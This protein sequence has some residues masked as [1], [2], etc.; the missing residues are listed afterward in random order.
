[1]LHSSFWHHGAVDLD[2]RA[3]WA[4]VL[5]P[6]PDPDIP[7]HD[8][9]KANS[10][11]AA[12]DGLFLDFLYPAKTL[13][14][15]R[16]L[17]GLGRENWQSRQMR[18]AK[19]GRARHFSSH[20][21]GSGDDQDDADSHPLSSQEH[22]TNPFD[23]SPVPLGDADHANISDD[24]QIP[25]EEREIDAWMAEVKDPAEA[26]RSLLK[27]SESDSR[28]VRRLWQITEESH[29]TPDLSAD[30]L[31]Y[32]RTVKPF[33]PTLA[34]QCIAIFDSLDAANRRP[35]SYRGVIKSHLTLGNLGKAAL[36]HQGCIESGK[37][38]SG[39]IG[40]ADLLA[41]AIKAKKWQVAVEVYASILPITGPSQELWSTA[42]KDLEMHELLEPVL[43]DLRRMRLLTGREP[44]EQEQIRAFV[45]DFANSTIRQF[46]PF[47][48]QPAEALRLYRLIMRLRQNAFLEPRHVEH[49]L[50]GLLRSPQVKETGR[51][52]RI[53]RKLYTMYTTSI[54]T[55]D[56]SIKV[57]GKV[58]HAMLLAVTRSPQISKGTR[59]GTPKVKIGRVVADMIRFFGKLKPDVLALL[60]G[61]YARVGD[62]KA[63]A[64]YF[65][66]IPAQEV[67]PSHLELL[68]EVHSTRG[69]VDGAA[70][71]IEAFLEKTGQKPTMKAWNLVLRAYA[72]KGD[73]AGASRIFDKMVESSVKPDA[74][75]FSA[76]LDLMSQR[77]DI[78]GVKDMFALAADT[79]GMILRST[80]VAGYLVTA[81][82]NSDD[83][84]TAEM[85]AEQLKKRK[86]SGLMEGPLTPIWNNLATAYALRRDVD[87]TRRI[88]EEMQAMGLEPD[89][90]TYAA[91]LQALCLVRN[92]DAA[93][94][95][96]RLVIPQK[97]VK[98][99]ALHWAIVMAG[100]VNQGDYEKVWHVEQHRRSQGVRGSLSTRSAVIKAVA[101]SEQAGRYRAPQDQ[102]LERTEKVLM[103]TLSQDDAWEFSA[104]PQTGLGLRTLDQADGAYLDI[105]MLIYGKR[106]AFEMVERLFQEYIKRHQNV[107]LSDPENAPPIRTLVALMTAHFH[108]GEH[109]RVED[110]WNLAV[111]Q[112]VRLAALSA[113]TAAV[114]P[115][116]TAQPRHQL[117]P[118]RRHLLGRPL[119]IYL[120][121][122][123]VQG[124][125]ANA[126][127]TVTSLLEQ[128]FTL[129]NQSWNLYVQILARTG[130]IIEAYS[131]CEKYLMPQWR[132]WRKADQYLK[133]RYR[134]TRGWDFM[135]V[136]PNLV[137][138]NMVMPQYRTMVI[139]GAALQYV[140]RQQAV[141]GAARSAGAIGEEPVSEALI[142]LKAPGTVAAVHAMPQIDDDLQARFLRN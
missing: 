65:K 136:N 35:T 132:G 71:H 82:I 7:E 131:L 38:S 52:P 47:S 59:V 107:S 118:N 90:L 108:A 124:R 101:M 31:D 98:P 37:A 69:D 123:H 33:I 119:V 121:T 125:Y 45:T 129:D 141:G 9:P 54:I 19:S 97:P 55:A 76:V 29:R 23:V 81:F 57:S 24:L 68:V 114:H 72:R 137:K 77:G 103:N 4:S 142:R 92:T 85:V 15:M 70:A 79:D 91:L 12:Q 49:A 105:V 60:M 26:L 84:E 11:S 32:F 25:D 88:Y 99:M 40:T 138:P 22:D 61:T 122:L 1:M 13:A 116:S 30:V 100:F 44:E 89:A 110:C 80:E 133:R 139:L 102:A 66:K 50:L 128:G 56:R 48:T 51:L 20:A 27:A 117:T 58:M 87:G 42:R 140:R 17:S 135:N 41:H 2:L 112:G 74:Y 63:V 86:E 95:I 83:V 21:N 36:I 62:V 115:A 46:A 106:R 78:D 134:I 64:M 113:P 67:T 3:W 14:L 28:M 94:K 73:L 16:R 43:L 109:D 10:R 120:R 75:S 93:Y 104:E 53:T 34:E 126:Q 130:R 96:L 8:G 39:N 111:E 5:P 6:L 127:A 18:V